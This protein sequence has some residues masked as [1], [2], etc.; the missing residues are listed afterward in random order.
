M[1]SN[2]HFQI[3][4][5]REFLEQ[6]RANEII[7]KDGVH[8]LDKTP[9]LSW[10]TFSS[11]TSKLKLATVP[12]WVVENARNEGIQFMET[13]QDIYKKQI[14]NF[15]DYQWPS[16]KIKYMILSFIDCLVMNQMKIIDVERHI[17]NGYWHGYV[18]V[19]VERKIANT[20][21]ICIIEVKTRSDW[22]VRETDRL[23]VGVYGEIMGC[24]Y[25]HCY[26]AIVN[27]N[28]FETRLYKQVGLG[29][30]MTQLDAFL[31]TLGQSEYKI[32]RWK[33]KARG[34]DLNSKEVKYEY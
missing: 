4:E 18:D 2:K 12:N 25:S 6:N 15:N 19:I 16:D 27:K 29:A 13:L 21:H 26:V 20:K 10:S 1:K 32:K 3:K 28:E 30:A 14:K 17:T 34:A 23:Q 11:W 5:Y 7:E 8:F 24:N 22:T 33:F 9:L 31:E